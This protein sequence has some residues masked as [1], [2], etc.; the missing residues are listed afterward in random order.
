MYKEDLELNNQQW[1][2]AIKPNQIRKSQKCKNE[3]RY[4]PKINLEELTC[5]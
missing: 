2:H 4:E 5:H 3:C 1:L